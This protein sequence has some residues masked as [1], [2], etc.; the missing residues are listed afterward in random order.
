[1]DIRSGSIAPRSPWWNCK[2]LSAFGET[3][4]AMLCSAKWEPCCDFEVSC[5]QTLLAAA[6]LVDPRQWIAVQWNCVST[7][8]NRFISCL[9]MTGTLASKLRCT[10]LA[11]LDEFH[12]HF[13]A[14]PLALQYIRAT[15]TISN[16]PTCTILYSWKQGPLGIL[17]GSG[18]C[19]FLCLAS[20]EV[21]SSCQWFWNWWNCNVE[22]RAEFLRELSR[23]SHAR[24]RSS[25]SS[26]QR[27]QMQQPKGEAA[28]IGSSWRFWLWLCN[29]NLIGENYRKL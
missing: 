2:T 12:W 3:D 4:E 11:S 10:S 19:L 9:E 13:L 21:M 22:T 16:R 8:M 20:I 28:T 5:I 23:G 15:K 24:K 17:H 26:W 1:M 25:Q 27:G 18:L 7:D 29:I 14:L 6:A